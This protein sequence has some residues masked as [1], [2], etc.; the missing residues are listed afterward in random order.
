V[1]HLCADALHLLAAGAW[2]GALVPLVSLLWRSSRNASAPSLRVTAQATRRFSTLGIAAVAA[3][4]L[5]GVVNATYAIPD[6]SAL[7][8]SQYG[9]LLLAKVALFVLIVC[10]AAR[11]RLVLTPRLS[12]GSAP[13]LRELRRNALAEA[14]L[15]FAIIAVVGKLGMTV[16]A[17]HTHMEGHH[18]HQGFASPVDTVFGRAADPAKARRTV[19]VVMTEMRFQPAEIT[20]HQGDV[21]RFLAI[22]QGEVP[23]EMVL[24]TLDD[25][26]KH[27]ELMKKTPEIDHA[28]PNMVHV[29]PG[30]SGEIGWQFT[31]SGEFYYGCLFPGH[32]E[33]GMVGRVTVLDR[34][35]PGH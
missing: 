16:P 21:V 29:A 22:N 8:E 17:I 15:G 11:N 33:A 34:E 14:A 18:A 27:A 5:S 35:R 2:L 19:R 7:F 31:R 1:A 25:L 13:A 30:K 9:R 3:L 6:V 24:G 23:H 4:L 12:G 28:G 26:K 10:F 32:L 20:V